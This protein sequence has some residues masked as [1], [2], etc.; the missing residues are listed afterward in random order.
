MPVSSDT[1]FGFPLCLVCDFVVSRPKGQW[2]RMLEPQASDPQRP[3]ELV[4]PLPDPLTVGK[5]LIL[6]NIQFDLVSCGLVGRALPCICLLYFPHLLSV[7]G[8]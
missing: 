7:S 8:G 1:I 6:D 4:A 3:G 2:G 5:A